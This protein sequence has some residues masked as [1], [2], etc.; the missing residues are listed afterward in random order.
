MIAF[1][2]FYFE[3]P[4]S[5]AADKSWNVNQSIC[6]MMISL[7]CTYFHISEKTASTAPSDGSSSCCWISISCIILSS[8]PGTSLRY[9]LAW[10]A[11]YVHAWSIKYVLRE[12][13]MKVYYKINWKYE[14]RNWFYQK[15]LRST[16]L[17]LNMFT[18]RWSL[19][20][21]DYFIT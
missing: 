19:F 1:V 6:N 21:M 5:K 2:R 13:K 17:Q 15:C 11:L 7:A 12:T 18:K 10:S 8:N 9:C 16:G 4:T 14:V 20:Q 3:Y